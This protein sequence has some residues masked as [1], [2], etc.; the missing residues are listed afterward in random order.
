MVNKKTF[1]IYTTTS[2]YKNADS[3]AGLSLKEVFEIDHTYSITSD[4]N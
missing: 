3:K 1:R 2:D 4:S